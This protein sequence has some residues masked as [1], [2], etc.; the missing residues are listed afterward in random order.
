MA[1]PA[2]WS[3]G[4]TLLL[5]LSLC[6]NVALIAFLFVLL[7][8]AVAGGF[9]GQPGGQLAPATIAQGLSPESQAKVR[10]VQAL[11]A[12]AM[13]QARQAARRTRLVA[14][15]IF[16]APNFNPDSFGQALEDVR[17]ADARLEEEAI[18]QLKDVINGLSPDERRTVVTR[19]RTGANRP[20]YRRWFTPA[21]VVQ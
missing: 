3:K 19:I 20:W 21:P 11:H 7:T 1:D 18:L 8:R 16:A 2:P 6:L 14:F 4:R 12:E 13:R 5:L 15:R 17:A 10:E 9:I